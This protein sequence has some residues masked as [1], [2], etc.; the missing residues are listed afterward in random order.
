MNQQI[1]W[2]TTVHMPSDENLVPIPEN[3]DVAIIGGGYTGLSAARTLATHGLRVAILEAETMAWGASSRNGG[4]VLTGLKLPMR[5]V[6]KRYGR[7]L[8]RQLFQYSLDSIDTVEK[9]VKEENIDCGFARTIMRSSKKWNLW[10]RSSTIGSSL[11]LA[12]S[13]TGRSGQTCFM[14]PLW[15]RSVAG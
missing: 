10:K 13:N 15:T 9:I 4:M 5:T 2:H 8:A 11:F 6:L 7:D 1:Y 12:S 3:V 14:A